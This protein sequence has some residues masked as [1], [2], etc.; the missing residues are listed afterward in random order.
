VL[1]LVFKESSSPIDHDIHDVTETSLPEPVVVPFEKKRY[2]GIFDNMSYDEYRAA[3]GANKSGLDNLHKSPL[4]YIT[5]KNNPK[6]PTQA[7]FVGRAMHTLILEPDKFNDEYVCIPKDAP[8]RPTKTQLGV[9]KPC[10]KTQRTIAFWEE[11][12]DENSGK[13]IIKNK[14]KN[15]TI[16]GVSDWDMIHLVRDA[17]MEHPIAN[18]LLQGE[19]ERSMWWVDE[20]T[21]KLC[22]GRVDVYN[23]S[24]NVIVDLKSTIDSSYSGFARSIHQYRYFVQDAFY[25]DGLRKSGLEVK[26]FIFVCVEKD[27]PY[28]VALY[29]LEPEWIRIGR[30]TYERDLEIYKECHESGKWPSY[31]PGARDQ[32]VP[33]YAKFHPIS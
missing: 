5:I 29:V 18:I 8:N 12:D 26:H 4:H 6:P 32:V 7:F 28:A 14:Q 9:E 10:L 23:E 20:N 11:F 22:K 17:V 19:V 16:W 33:G 13:I 27:P 25:T 1:N 30:E 24:H 15:D 21:K 31:P 2:L 3:P